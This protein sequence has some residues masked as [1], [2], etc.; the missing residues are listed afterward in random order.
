MFSF[1]GCDALKK[2]MTLHSFFLLLFLVFQPFNVSAAGEFQTYEVYDPYN[3][4][5]TPLHYNS[6]NDSV[7]FYISGT[8]AKKAYF[9]SYTDSTFSTPSHEKTLYPANYGWTYFMGMAFDCNTYYVGILY[10]SNDN[11]LVRVKL[12]ITG[13]VNPVCDSTSV[14]TGDN[15]QEECSSCS[16]FNCPGW[17]QYMSKLDEIKN[18]IPP[19]PNWNQIAQTF[20]DTIVPRMISDLETML[21]TAPTPVTSKPQLPPIETHGIENE[22]PQMN[23]IPGLEDSV[24][25]KK[26]IEDQA[27]EIQFRDDPT[28]GFDLLQNPIEAL[29]SLPDGF[30]MP[31]KDGG[32]WDEHKPKEEFIPFPESP[33]NSDV[34][35]TDPP[36][37]STNVGSSP[38]PGQDFGTPPTPGTGGQFDGT[39]YYKNHPDDPDGSGG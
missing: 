32:E 31:G 20:R 6:S 34:Q 12:H 7:D 5:T 17:D 24:F 22:V 30:P 25:T 29:P 9:A 3:L 18:A 10:D 38:L 8:Q 4:I 28:G 2:T 26:D 37:P 39:K 19:A 1:K 13:L 15:Q 27:E 14:G 35:I 11:V 23:D 33:Q 36:L 16:L 21:G